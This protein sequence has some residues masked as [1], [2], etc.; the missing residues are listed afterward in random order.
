MESL[1]EK[2]NSST[3]FFKYVFNF[4]GDSKGEMINLVQYSVLAIIP[5]V[6]LNKL[7]QRFVPEVDEDKGSI[8]I[9]VEVIIQV[10]VMFIGLLFINRI[11]TYIPTFSKMA[12]PEIQIIFFVLPV[13]M[14]ILSLQTRIGEKVSILTDR[15]KELWDGKMSNSSSSSNS[16]NKQG[17]SNSQNNKNIRVSQPISN[18]GMGNMG[19]MG[20]M[21]TMN[22]NAQMMSLQS[23]QM[24]NDGTAI[25]QLPTYSQPSS[26]S[27]SGSS[28]N[29]QQLPDYNAMYQL[30]STPMIGASSP[31][32]GVVPAS[33]LLGGFFSGSSF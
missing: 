14:I 33:E 9:L 6:I 1:E 21:N 2:A 32:G 15:V 19:A 29:V 4:D 28:G 16:K 26:G 12:Y 11:I 23:S 25:N 17:Q 7:I 31:G 5:V 18:N 13:L 20:G 22:N 3:G 8:E 27:S 30:D 10:I 24:Y